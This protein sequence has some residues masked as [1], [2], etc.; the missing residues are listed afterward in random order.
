MTAELSLP[1]SLSR[2]P[3]E[4][5]TGLFLPNAHANQYCTAATGLTDATY[6]ENRRIACLADQLGVAFALTVARWKGIPGDSVGYARYGLDTVTLAGA[7][8]EATQRLVILSTMHTPVWNPVVAA[9]LGADLDHIGSGRWGMNIVAGWS[10][11]EFRSLGISMFPDEQRYE[12]AADW[13]SAVRELWQQG[14][15]SYASS[16]FSLEEAECRPRPLQRG[17]PTVVNAGASPRGMRF[18][19]ENCDYLFTHSANGEEFRRVREELHSDVGYIGLKRVILGRTDAEAAEKAD[20]IV[21]AADVRAIAN[22]WIPAGDPAA[23]GKAEATRRSLREDE[24]KLRKALLDDALIGTPEGVAAEL[25][26][27]VSETSVDGVCLALFDYEPSLSLM[28]GKGLETLGNELSRV[29]RSLVL[30]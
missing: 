17:G 10:E 15:T 21:Q 19:I 20:R 22:R 24:S 8:L 25:A 18:A 4:V 6:E 12:Q 9:K 30:S 16:F 28:A 1:K 26:T 27:W 11:S 3:G 23:A 7:L 2:R 29:G 5:R 13:L 14:E